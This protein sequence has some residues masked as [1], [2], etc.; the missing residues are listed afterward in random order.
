MF[1]FA[2][3][4]VPPGQRGDRVPFA[5]PQEVAQDAPVYDQLA[6]WLGRE[7]RWVAA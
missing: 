4:T 1:A 5:Q 7:P 6:G 2:R 3:T